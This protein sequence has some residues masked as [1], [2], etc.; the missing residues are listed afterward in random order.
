MTKE[1]KERKKKGIKTHYTVIHYKW[2]KNGLERDSSLR[3]CLLL[4]GGIILIKR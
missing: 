1:A 3:I 2:M 4:Q